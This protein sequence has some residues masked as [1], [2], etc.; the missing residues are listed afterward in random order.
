MEQAGDDQVLTER[1]EQGDWIKHYA[2]N[3]Q[4]HSLEDFADCCHY[5]QT[6][7]QSMFTRKRLCTLY[8]PDGRVTLSD[9]HLITT[10][11]GVRE[12][13][14]LSDEEAFRKALRSIFDIDLDL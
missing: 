10:H 12:E 13:Q 3:F 2:F 11:S 6:S 8:L 7:P 9:L 4:P 14:D 1:N 5:H